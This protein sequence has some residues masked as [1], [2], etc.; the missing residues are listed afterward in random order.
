MKKIF[1][2]FIALLYACS[3]NPG[4]PSHPAIASHNL[5]SVK[6]R[7]VADQK[8]REEKL[9]EI[10]YDS[11]LDAKDQLQDY[12][13]FVINGKFIVLQLNADTNLA[14]GNPELMGREIFPVTVTRNLQ[15]EKLAD[16][17]RSFIGKKFTL[18]SPNGKTYHTTIKSLKFLVALYEP[19]GMEEM[20]D[21]STNGNPV[22]ASRVWR[23]ISGKNGMI[24]GEMETA[25]PD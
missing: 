22:S 19:Y 18:V 7:I 23:D 12:F 17:L 3:G 8:A 25:F 11:L 20:M 9:A 4:K 2:V 24:A 14:T 6:T 15:M 10:P 1:P 13:R 5:D 21:D 16:S